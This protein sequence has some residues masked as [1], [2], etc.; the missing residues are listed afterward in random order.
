MFVVMCDERGPPQRNAQQPKRRRLQRLPPVEGVVMVSMS[1]ESMTGMRWR[2]ILIDSTTIGVFH[3]ADS[4]TVADN[5]HT[6][7]AVTLSLTCHLSPRERELARLYTKTPS[8]L[9]PVCFFASRSG[10]WPI[11]PTD[12][13]LHYVPTHTHKQ[14]AMSEG[15]KVAQA[16]AEVRGGGGGVVARLRGP[17]LS[18]G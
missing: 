18:V 9:S 17:Q 1:H 7:C 11:L 12:R 15:D 13:T 3:H 10:V 5:I 4:L 6:R 8:L 2:W 14:A 16:L